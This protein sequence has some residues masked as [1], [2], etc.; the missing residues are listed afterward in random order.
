V[1]RPASLHLHTEFRKARRPRAGFSNSGLVSQLNAS[2]DSD[3][4]AARRSFPRAATAV[5]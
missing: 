5:C 2:N 4:M 3:D 1:E